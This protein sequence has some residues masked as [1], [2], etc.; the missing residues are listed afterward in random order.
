MHAFHIGVQVS[1]VATDLK[2][3]S[4]QTDYSKESKCPYHQFNQHIKLFF[5][6]V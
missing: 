1:T 6:T 3:C 4:T 2:M 5:A